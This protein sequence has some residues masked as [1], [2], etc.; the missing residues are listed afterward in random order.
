MG[1]VYKIEHIIT[2]RIEAMKFLPAGVT[3][4]PEELQRFE[5]E[6]QVQARL[7][8]PN[9]AAL[10]NAVRDGSSIALIMEYVEGES[11]QRILERGRLPL[12]IAVNYAGQVLDA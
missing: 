2:K 1:A 3:G 4:G 11:L 6:I 9:I 7:S 10:Y 12:H 8:H 5:R